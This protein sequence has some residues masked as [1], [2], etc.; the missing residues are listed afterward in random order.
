[1]QVLQ[2]YKLLTEPPV[3]EVDGIS[4]G[5]DFRTMRLPDDVNGWLR[6]RERAFARE[7]PGVRRWTADDFAAEMVSKPWWSDERTWLAVDVVA[8][9]RLVGAATLAQRDTPTLSLPVVHW[10]LVDPKSRRRGIGRQLMMRLEQDAWERG[11]REVRL[12]THAGWRAA[13]AL[14]R[15]LGYRP[16]S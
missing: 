8:E 9:E 16:A 1:M 5:L 2:M 3:V 6:L 10:L 7:R 14:Y 12:E 11:F 13:V 4:R 15:A